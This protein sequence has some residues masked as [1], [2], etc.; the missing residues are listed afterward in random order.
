MKRE[1]HDVFYLSDFSVSGNYT[2][3]QKHFQLALKILHFVKSGRKNTIAPSY[4]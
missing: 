1:D 4:I 2:A 3:L